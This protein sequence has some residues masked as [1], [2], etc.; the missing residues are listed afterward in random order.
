M[1][2][3]NILNKKPNLDDLIIKNDKLIR[4]KDIDIDGFQ[5]L[6]FN[7]LKS[8]GKTT[9]IYALLCSLFG[10]KVYTLKSNIIEIEKKIFKFRSSIYHLEIDCIEIINNERLFFNDY[11]KDYISTRN[12]GLDIPK[13]I[14]LTNIEKIS[15]QS[16]LYLRKIIEDSF[17][18]AK[19][20]FE[21]NNMNIIPESIRSR[22]FNIRISVPKK[23]EILQVIDK[24]LK[25]NKKKIPNTII[26]KIMDNEK[27]YQN[28]YHFF[29]IMNGINYYIETK[30]FIYNQFY[31]IVDELFKRIT[32]KNITFLNIQN[33]KSLLEKSFINYYNSHELMYVLNNQLYSKYINNGLMIERINQV[34]IKCDYA[35]NHC[36]GKYFIHLEN[37]IIQIILIIHNLDIK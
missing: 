21:T 2:D 33:I 8:T 13:I 22:F 17:K 23:E 31:S 15:N 28:Y 1:M 4:Y 32:C 29:N 27:K 30:S 7:G 19:F 37:Y 6:I 36:T 14:Y 5:N 20:I 10:E 9:Q 26:S 24:G 3:I 25:E 11:L 34:A 12:I 35:L 16:F 18:S